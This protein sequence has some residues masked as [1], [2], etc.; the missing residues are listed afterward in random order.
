LL[1]LLIGSLGRPIKL[2]D[3]KASFVDGMGGESVFE[4]MWPYVSHLVDASVTLSLRQIADAVSLLADRN[5]IVAEGAGAATLAAAL[6]DDVP[7][8]NIVCV[9]S[10]G[11]IDLMKL[12][13]I[14][15]GD[16]PQ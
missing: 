5:S 10:G 9:I 8:G 4:S 15:H 12:A 16:I 13:T 7:G 14:F 2:E 1:L 3:R 6:S 11:N